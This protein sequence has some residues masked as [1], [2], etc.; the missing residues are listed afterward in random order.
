VRIKNY[1]YANAAHP[2]FSL[3]NSND[4]AFDKKL[5]K[6]KKLTKFNK[7]KFPDILPKY[8]RFVRHKNGEK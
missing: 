5:E 4:R 8:G 2:N 1:F 7:M 6:I 3:Y